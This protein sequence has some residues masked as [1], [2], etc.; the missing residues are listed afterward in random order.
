[1]S[2]KLR[3]VCL[4]SSLLWPTVI[5][6][7]LASSYNLKL[8]RPT[9]DFSV[10]PWR[11]N[12]VNFE[13]VGQIQHLRHFRA[14]SIHQHALKKSKYTLLLSEVTSSGFI[15]FHNISGLLIFISCS[16]IATR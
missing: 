12:D 2:S 15:G 11:T 8:I 5:M 6:R 9:W 1:M 4:I 3:R 7:I 13:L 14:S 10:R 16:I